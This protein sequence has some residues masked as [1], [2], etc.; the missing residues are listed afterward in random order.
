MTPLRRTIRRK[1][2]PLVRATRLTP[3][4]IAKAAA[5][6]RHPR[7]RPDLSGLIL[8]GQA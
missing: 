7:A 2:P 8:Y 6:R 1:A 4:A 5:L 3:R